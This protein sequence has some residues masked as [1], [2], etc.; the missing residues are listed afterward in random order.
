[1]AVFSKCKHAI[2]S[3]TKPHPEWVL[4]NVSIYRLEAFITRQL[5]ADIKT[6][7]NQIFV[8]KHITLAVDENGNI[9]SDS[10]EYLS[11][12]QALTPDWN[13]IWDIYMW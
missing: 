12:K 11:N 10:R 1:M 6:E 2:L 7:R 4:E 13:Q 3:Y 9:I 8:F 5:D